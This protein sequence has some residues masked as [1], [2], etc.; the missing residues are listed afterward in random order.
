MTRSASCVAGSTALGELRSGDALGQAVGELRSGGALGQPR[1]VED[2]A[3][4]RS[5]DDTLG[6][7]R[8]VEDLAVRRQLRSGDL[9]RRSASCR[10]GQLCHVEDLAVLGQLRS[11]DV[12][13]R[14]GEPRAP[15]GASCAPVTCSAARRAACTQR[16]QLPL[17]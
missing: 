13:R 7:P 12:L 9:L 4:P 5:G 1:R 16:R 14:L 15:S 2:L 10:S 11:G 8:R 17:R 3:A 6:Q